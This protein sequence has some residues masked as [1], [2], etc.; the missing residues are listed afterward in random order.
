MTPIDLTIIVLGVILPLLWFFRESLP[1][2]GGKPRSTGAPVAASKKKEEEG[3]P[4]DFVGKM[5]RG[6]SWLLGC[7]DTY[8]LDPVHVG[9][10]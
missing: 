2:I 6:V 1:I 3:D 4:R 5:Q 8:A 10:G 9:M 7:F